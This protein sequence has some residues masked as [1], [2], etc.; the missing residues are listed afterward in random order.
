MVHTVC[1]HFAWQRGVKRNIL[2]YFWLLKINGFHFQM[3]IIIV[4][5][6]GDPIGR[7]AAQLIWTPKI[8]PT[9]SHQPGSIYQLI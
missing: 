9:L 2:G 5:D 3:M 4:V 7:P 1:H 8:S 6:E